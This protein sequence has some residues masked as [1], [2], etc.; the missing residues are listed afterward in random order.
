LAGDSINNSTIHTRHGNETILLAEDDQ[1]IMELTTNCLESCGYR[2]I[3]ANDGVEAVRLFR[4]HPDEIDLVLLDAIMPKM[5]GKQAW[6]E[7]SAI[8]PNVKAC[9]VSGYSNDII[10]GKIAVDFSVPFVSK[11]VMPDALLKKIRDILDG[12]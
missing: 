11:P 10:S 5:T 8:R 12:A 1:M 3:Q 2:V 7:I 6:D 4:K 9:F